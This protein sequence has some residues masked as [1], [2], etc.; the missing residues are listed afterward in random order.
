MP[1]HVHFILDVREAT[2][3]HLGTLIKHIKNECYTRIVA[4]GYRKD[5]QIFAA[6]KA[7]HTYE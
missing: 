5:T 6:T 7:M 4:I 3:T 2:D 1:D